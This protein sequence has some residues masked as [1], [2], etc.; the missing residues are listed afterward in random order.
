MDHAAEAHKAF[1]RQDWSVATSHYRMALQKSPGDLLLHY[2]LAISASWL[3]LRDEATNEFEW[4]VAH[5]AATS[6]EHR[7]AVDWLAGAR[8]NVARVA[9]TTSDA[10]ARDERAGDSGVH[11]RIVW[12]EGQG[13]G[14]EP[15][16]RFQV[17]LYGL[18]PDGVPK[19]ISFHV[20]TDRDG[21]YK[22]EKIPA[23]IYKM[24]DNN[25][26]AP[27]WRLRVEVRPG[28]DALI[29]LGPENGVKTRDDFPKPS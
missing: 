7:V 25:V 16:K 6:E 11:G 15:L 13:Q 27:K 17:H 4:I 28:E 14:I 23:G 22:F 20:R 24:T 8:R 1:E 9:A 21:N 12:D 2:R 29:N 3:D 18:A 10:D 19:G 26:G 5:T